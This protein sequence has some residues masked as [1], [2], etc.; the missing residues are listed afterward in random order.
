M[1]LAPF[2]NKLN[3]DS[4]EESIVKHMVQSL[5]FRVS[6]V[7]RLVTTNIPNSAT[8]TYNLLLT[9]LNRYSAEMRVQGKVAAA[10]ASIVATRNRN[11]SLCTRGGF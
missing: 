4:L 1:E 9:R 11:V 8:A 5:N 6:E 7:I 10:E 3:A 2:P